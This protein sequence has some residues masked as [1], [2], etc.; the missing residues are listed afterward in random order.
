MKS[1][2]QGLSLNT[3]IIAALVLIVL[4]VLVI[5]FSGRM[6]RFGKTLTE[7]EDTEDLCIYKGG[8]CK[9]SCPADELIYGDFR[10]CTGTKDKCCKI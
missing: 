2:A 10:D 3:I 5:I 4:V 7:A 8:V 1:K 9:E 6:G